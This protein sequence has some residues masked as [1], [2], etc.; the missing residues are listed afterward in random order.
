M[1]PSLEEV[2]EWYHGYIQR[3]PDVEL[4]EALTVADKDFLSAVSELTEE[5]GLYRYA[6]GKW[7]VKDVI[8]H[9]SDAE[10]VFAYRALRYAREDGTILHSFDQDEYVVKA[11]ADDRSIESLVTEYQ[12]IR[13]AS[14]TLFESNLDRLGNGGKVG[15]NK[16]TV[17]SLGYVIAGH[18]L[19][20]TDIIRDKYLAA[21]S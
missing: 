3:V 10:R 4:L 21:F 7:S 13:L 9:I 11:G 6:P 8:Q 18:Q 12:A 20:H 14:F 19:H 15:E 5:Q 17:N 16:F 1:K 2:P